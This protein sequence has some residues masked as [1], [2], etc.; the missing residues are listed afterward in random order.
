LNHAI[1]YTD[2]NELGAKGFSAGTLSSAHFERY[3]DSDLIHDTA[4]VSLNRINRP[5]AK[6]SADM[7]EIVN[8]AILIHPLFQGYVDYYSR[9]LKEAG[10]FLTTVDHAEIRGLVTA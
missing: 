2:F 9:L 8:E 7:F 1:V 4:I 3:C 10:P 5:V 6:V